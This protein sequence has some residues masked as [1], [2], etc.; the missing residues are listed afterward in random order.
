M[1][2]VDVFDQIRKYFGIDLTHRTMKYTIRLFEILWSMILAQAY[3]IHRRLHYNSFRLLSHQ[4]F[5][6]HVSRGLLSHSVVRPP[7]M[8]PIIIAHELKQQEPGSK[9]GGSNRRKRL[10]CRHC[11]NKKTT[12]YCVRCQVGFHPE[13]FNAWHSQHSPSFVPPTKRRRAAEEGGSD[14]EDSDD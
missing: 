8:A 3:N 9:G 11:H 4:Q 13:C 7:A 1:H 2:A 14:G 12:W 6:V 5:K 10:V